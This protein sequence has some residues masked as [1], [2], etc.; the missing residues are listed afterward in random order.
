MHCCIF[1]TSCTGFCCF[2]KCYVGIMSLDRWVGL[3]RGTYEDACPSLRR[4][5]PGARELFSRRVD[6][7]KPFNVLT[8]SATTDGRTEPRGTGAA[9]Q[10]SFRLRTC[11][12]SCCTSVLPSR[13]RNAIFGRPP[14]L[15]VRRPPSLPCTAWLCTPIGER[16]VEK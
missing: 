5:H 3:G 2:V 4:R 12:G 14:P 11:A 7:A 10:H 16:G 15:P 9:V 8:Y 6:V 1:G 13:Q